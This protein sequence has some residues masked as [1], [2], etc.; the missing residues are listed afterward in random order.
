MNSARLPIPKK[1]QLSPS[2]LQR[3]FSQSTRG[4]ASPH[5]SPR[6]KSTPPTT[7]EFLTP[8]LGSISRLSPQPT[9]CASVSRELL[10]A[11][12]LLRGSACSERL[13]PPPAPR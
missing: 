8:P 9:S 11:S 5:T 2:P 4:A 6:L 13:F 1:A 3:P 10:P 7:L 12:T